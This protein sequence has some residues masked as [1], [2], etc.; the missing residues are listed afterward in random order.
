MGS[1]NHGDGFQNFL[2]VHLGTRAVEITDDVGHTGLEAH[3]GSQVDGLAGI[4]AG[5]DLIFPWSRL[6]RLQG[7]ETE[8]TVAGSFKFT[9]RLQKYQMD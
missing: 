2:L 8:R 9:M 5:K 1:F 3:E 7:Q 6:A 4:V